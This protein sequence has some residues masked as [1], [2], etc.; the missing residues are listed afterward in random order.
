MLTRS[1]TNVNPE[2]TFSSFHVGAYYYTPIVCEMNYLFL[3]KEENRDIGKIGS[4][5][6]GEYRKL[7]LI[8]ANCWSK[9]SSSFR[10]YVMNP[11]NGCVQKH[12]SDSAV[13]QG[14]NGTMLSPLSTV[15]SP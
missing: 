11:L 12:Y 5:C 4:G 2:K 6:Q 13:L 9:D 1:R 15:H 3:H 14:K 8:E 7:L 10:V